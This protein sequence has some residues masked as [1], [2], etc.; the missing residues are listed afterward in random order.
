MASTTQVLGKHHVI[1]R[2]RI[3]FILLCMMLDEI[4]SNKADYEA[5]NSFSSEW[6]E[7]REFGFGPGVVNV[8]LE[9]IVQNQ[10]AR[11]EFDNLLSC[12][13]KQIASWGTA[14][15]KEILDKK[16]KFYGIK[17]LEDLD[18]SHITSAI[19]KIK[20]LLQKHDGETQE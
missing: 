3:L 15:P 18:T 11:L 4:D 8:E 10:K 14:I 13:E 17:Y 6:R 9:D 20:E 16:Y 12:A 7:Y 19:D 2:D 5:I 1:I